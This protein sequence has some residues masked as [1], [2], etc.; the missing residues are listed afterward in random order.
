MHELILPAITLV[1]THGHTA[2]YTIEPL[3]PGY[4]WTLGSTL[5]RALLSSL[6]GLAITGLRITGWSPKCERLPGM[7]ETVSEF[8]LNCKQVRLRSEDREPHTCSLYLEVAGKRVVTA[9]AL[10]VPAG[11]AITTP[12]VHLAILTSEDANLS[13]EMVVKTGRG[14]MPVEAQE[15]PSSGT[16]PV[17]AIYSPVR[18]VNYTIEKTRVGPMVNYEKIELEITTDG[19]LTP[20]DALR[21]SATFLLRHYKLFA[22]FDAER[23]PTKLEPPGAVPIP[24]WIDGMLLEEIGLP[25]RTYNSLK[26]HAIT[27][28]GQ[29]LAMTEEELRGIRNFG[30]QALQS[31]EERVVA[32]NLLP[33][34]H[35]SSDRS[36]GDSCRETEPSGEGL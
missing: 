31:L 18:T 2:T 14:Y 5:H 36:D 23:T 9:R 4:G 20:D 33:N 34:R 10:A 29:V 30:E 12:D 11:V 19:T 17:D 27:R 24:P 22:T 16:I 26:R 25:L 13:V 32:L 8:V 7:K 1:S 35:E 28:V 15:E 6:P 3:T 21:S